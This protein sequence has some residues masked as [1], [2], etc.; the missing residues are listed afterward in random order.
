MQNKALSKTNILIHHWMNKQER[1]K[2]SKHYGTQFSSSKT[3]QLYRVF[4]WN[5]CCVSD[6]AGRPDGGTLVPAV[7]WWLGKKE[8]QTARQHN[9][10][11][12]EWRRNE[13]MTFYSCW[14][15]ARCWKSTFTKIHTINCVRETICKTFSSFQME[16]L[17]LFE[18]NSPH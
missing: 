16:D 8:K 10:L 5:C 6:E 17:S 12:L 4:F 13:A 2:K 15:Q 11:C 9:N 3:Q 14:K 1:K 7:K 18:K